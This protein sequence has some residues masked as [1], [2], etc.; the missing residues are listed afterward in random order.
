[1]RFT[2]L[3][4]GRFLA[5]LSV[6]VFHTAAYADRDLLLPN[7][8]VE[9]V[10]AYYFRSAVV[11]FFSLSGFVLAHALQRMSIRDYLKSRFLRLFPAYWIAMAIVVFVRSASGYPFHFD[12]KS[13]INA[14]ALW[15][16]GPNRSAYT[17]GIEWTLVYEIFLSL[18]L[19]PLALLGRKTGLIIGCGLWFTAIVSRQ[20]AIGGGEFHQFPKPGELPLA[21]MN[22]AFVLG[23][24]CYFAKDR[25]PFHPRFALLVAIPMIVL[26]ASYTQTALG[27]S[28]IFQSIGTTALLAAFARGRQLS[29]RNLLVRAGDWSYGIY[30]FHVPALT[31]YF[32]VMAAAGRLV[33]PEFVAI[34]GVFVALLVSSLF[35]LVE[36]TIYR[37][38]RQHSGTSR[39]SWSRIISPIL[40]RMRIS[41]SEP[42]SIRNTSL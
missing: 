39:L 4:A 41:K 15:P 14:I 40:R 3:Q 34:S 19:V 11:F 37:Q 17:L 20:I 30:L 12:R 22:S 2:N 38:I 28:I 6:L 23:V 16:A 33:S 32:A 36:W 21:V 26:G 27:W 18:A 31:A 7:A 42:L 25:L 5:A 29:E 13:L 24:L 10:P 9:P 1:M 35:G 8:L